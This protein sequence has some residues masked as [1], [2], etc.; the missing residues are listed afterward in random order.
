MDHS[1]A[2]VAMKYGFAMKGEI[3]LAFAMKS[4]IILAFAMNFAMKSEIISAFHLQSE[5]LQTCEN[6]VPTVS[7][8][9]S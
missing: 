8:T 9:Q 7:S 4:E 6:E 2:K 1:L 3:I 5:V